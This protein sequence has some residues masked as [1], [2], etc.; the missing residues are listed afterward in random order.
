M[1]GLAQ[2]L[3]SPPQMVPTPVSPMPAARAEVLKAS[4]MAPAPEA[5][6]AAEGNRRSRQ[7]AAGHRR[8][9]FGMMKPP[10]RDGI[11]IAKVR[12]S[13]WRGRCG[14]KETV[15]ATSDR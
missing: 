1:A 2:T 14:G 12:R 5:A 8:E 10:N 15:S 3:A 9:S 13:Y 4:E 7:K 6:R 11:G